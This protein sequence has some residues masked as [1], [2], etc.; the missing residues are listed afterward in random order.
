MSANDMYGYTLDINGYPSG[1]LSSPAPSFAFLPPPP[2]YFRNSTVSDAELNPN[3]NS[4]TT[5]TSN[6]SMQMY[7]NASSSLSQLRQSSSSASQL[8]D[9]EISASPPKIVVNK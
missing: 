3:A 7:L 9:G 4:F 2:M 1:I 8:T 6:N 5:D